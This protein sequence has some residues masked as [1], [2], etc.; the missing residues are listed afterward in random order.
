MPT[1]QPGSNPSFLKAFVVS[2]TIACFA[3]HKDFPAKSPEKK[4]LPSKICEKVFLLQNNQHFFCF[5]AQ[6]K[7][8]AP[9]KGWSV[10]SRPGSWGLNGQIFKPFEAMLLFTYYPHITLITLLVKHLRLLFLHS[11]L[12]QSTLTQN[13]SG[14]IISKHIFRWQHLWSLQPVRFFFFLLKMQHAT[15]GTSVATYKLMAVPF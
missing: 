6:L 2:R 1:K 14:S 10:G 5:A 8:V 3:G 13:K 4:L 12:F 7:D 15:S 11:T 9:Q